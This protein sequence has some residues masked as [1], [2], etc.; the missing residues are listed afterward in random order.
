MRPF[1]VE[2]FDEVIELGLLLQEVAAGRLGGLELQG[3]MHALMASVLLRM[4]WLDALDLD[5]EPEP[6]YRL[7]PQARAQPTVNRRR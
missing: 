5:A 4:A 7:A 3:E 1:I 2:A 6:P